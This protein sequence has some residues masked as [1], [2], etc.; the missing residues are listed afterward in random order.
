[1]LSAIPLLIRELNTLPD[2]D[3]L[4]IA[5]PDEGAWKRFHAFFSKQWPTVTCIKTR[6]GSK[7]QVA[8][9]EGEGCG[10]R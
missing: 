2:V 8:I 1:L 7:R 5:F 4:T 3:N 10:S 6:N 9:R